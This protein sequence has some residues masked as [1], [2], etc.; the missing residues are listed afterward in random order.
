LFIG[1]LDRNLREDQLNQTLENAATIAEL[2]E[3]RVADLSTRARPESKTLLAGILPNEIQ[4][5]GYADDWSTFEMEA[6]QY[7]YSMNKVSIDPVDRELAASFSVHAAVRRG[8]LYL[9]IRVIDRFA[10]RHP[11]LILAD[12]LVMQLKASGQ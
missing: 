7:R 10:G 4:I 1:E 9:F 8:Y 11:G 3:T 12:T 5:D 2:A 6:R